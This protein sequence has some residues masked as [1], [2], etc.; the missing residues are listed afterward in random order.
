MKL[1]SRHVRVLIAGI[2]LAM[3]SQIALGQDKPQS[4]PKIQLGNGLQILSPTRGADFSGYSR[5]LLVAIKRNW[6]A[7]LP[8]SVYSGQTGLVAVIVQVREDGT[9]LNPDPTIVRSSNRDALDAAAVAA[10]R[11]S[12]PF[13]HFPAAF[14]GTTLE[15]RITFY[16]NIPV[17]KP[18]TSPE[19]AKSEPSENPPK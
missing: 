19:P 11:A 7:S 9:L 16:Y 14:E 13:P 18:V 3:W 5:D 4:R 2:F 8:E 17:K 1:T 6:I 15:L 10:I 12:A